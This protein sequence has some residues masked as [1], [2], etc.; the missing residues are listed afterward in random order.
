MRRVAVAVAVLLAIFGGQARAVDPADGTVIYEEPLHIPKIGKGVTPYRQYH[1]QWAVDDNARRPQVGTFATRPSPTTQLASK[2]WVVTDCSTAACTAGSGSIKC[3]TTVND[4][5]NAWQVGPCDG[6]SSTAAFSSLTG[7][8]NTA[9]AMVV[10]TGASLTASGT[11]TITATG[12]TT[13]NLPSTT[14]TGI[15]DDAVLVGSGAG[16]SAFKA[17]PTT[18]TNGCAGTSDKLLY[19]TGTNTWSCGTDQTGGGGGVTDGDKGDVVV[20]GSGTI[21]TV[22]SAAASMALWP[23]LSAP[24]SSPAITSILSF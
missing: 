9:A 12:A 11:G 10:G 23:T 14:L 2:Q 21:W 7:G 1:W 15:T 19:N 3:M 18:G 6:T 16:T 4:A 8:T 20:S 5:G 24:A 17:L 13:L 22:E